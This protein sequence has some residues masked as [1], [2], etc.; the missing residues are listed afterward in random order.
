[1]VVIAEIPMEVNQLPMDLQL[2]YKPHPTNIFNLQDNELLIAF[3]Y[4]VIK[5]QMS[6]FF[7]PQDFVC[8]SFLKF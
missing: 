7:V 8:S 5:K 3:Q 2:H 6:C 4:L 1:M